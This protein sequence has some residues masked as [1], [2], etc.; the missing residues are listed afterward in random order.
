M[1]EMATLAA[2][3]ISVKYKYNCLVTDLSI[4]LRLWHFIMSGFTSWGFK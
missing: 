3:I 2:L 1:A 4:L